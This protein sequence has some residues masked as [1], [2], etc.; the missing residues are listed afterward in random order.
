MAL[1]G[2]RKAADRAAGL[3]NLVR[4][5]EDTF[6]EWSGVDDAKFSSALSGFQTTVAAACGVPLVVRALRDYHAAAA[7]DAFECCARVINILAM[8]NEAICGEM[9]A[10]GCVPPLV[11][12]LR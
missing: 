8:K 11:E 12:L 5:A 10:A 1:L 3:R 4:V 2:S 7:A 9:G 6:S